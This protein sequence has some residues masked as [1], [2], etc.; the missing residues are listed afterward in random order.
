MLKKL[1]I[2]SALIFFLASHNL[3][4][5]TVSPQKKEKKGVTSGEVSVV[6]AAKK[7]IGVSGEEENNFYEVD[8]HTRF[9]KVSKLED[10]H[11]G[12]VVRLRYEGSLA[13]SI[14]LIERA[15]K[16]TTFKPCPERNK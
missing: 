14:D 11:Q 16:E 8:S 5:Q 7:R 15:E 6:D 12:D 1:S 10:I 13:Q 2:I 3:A 9:K 4:A